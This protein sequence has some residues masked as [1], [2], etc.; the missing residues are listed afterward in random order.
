MAPKFSSF[1]TENNSS[2]NLHQNSLFLQ[3]RVI[4]TEAH[5][6]SM[7]REYGDVGC[8]DLKATNAQCLQSFQTPPLRHL[9]RALGRKTVRGKDSGVCKEIVFAEHDRAAAHVNWQWLWLQTCTRSKQKN[10]VME[11]GRA[12]EFTSISEDLLTSDW[13]NQSFVFLILFLR[14]R[15][16]RE[17]PALVDSPT[18]MH[19]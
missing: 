14:R 12:H 13:R 10:P 15:L 2:L 1:Y 17:I 16:L 5:N 8:L 6:W 11:G 18:P 19:V 4:N 9:Y 3:K 7:S